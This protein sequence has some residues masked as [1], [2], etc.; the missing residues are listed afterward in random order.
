MSRRVSRQF[1]FSISPHSLISKLASV[2]SNNTFNINDPSS[3]IRRRRQRSMEIDP[4]ITC[5]LM[6]LAVVG[7]ALGLNVRLK[8]RITSMSLH[9][10]GLAMINKI[11]RSMTRDLVLPDLADCSHTRESCY[12]CIIIL[13]AF[14]GSLCARWVLLEVLV[15][16][17]S[18]HVPAVLPL[19]TVNGAQA[20]GLAGLDLAAPGSAQRP[21]SKS[22]WAIAFQRCEDRQHDHREMPPNT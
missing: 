16:L 12:R 19:V 5:F 18:D 17:R 8:V 1:S 21:K 4:L 15:H 13:S 10:T 6:I 22:A 3:F 7:Q 2:L 9:Q 11:G 20:D 14:L